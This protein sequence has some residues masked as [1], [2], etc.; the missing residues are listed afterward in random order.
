[1]VLL[2]PKTF[3]LS[4]GT[5]QFP[6]EGVHSLLLAFGARELRAFGFGVLR[7]CAV[8]ILTWKLQDDNLFAKHWC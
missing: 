5:S 7:I 6:P 4:T 1:M 2:K 8:R 3:I